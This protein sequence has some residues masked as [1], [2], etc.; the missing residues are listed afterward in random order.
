M[1]LATLD[2]TPEP[3]RADQHQAW[4]RHLEARGIAGEEQSADHVLGVA[5]HWYHSGDTGRADHW[6]RLAAESASQLDAAPEAALHWQRVLDLKIATGP[7]REEVVMRLWRA[8][9]ASGQTAES[10]ALLRDELNAQPAPTGLHRLNLELML[11]QALEALPNADTMKAGPTVHHVTRLAREVL[12][13]PGKRGPPAVLMSVLCN[14]LSR[15]DL[16]GDIVVAAERI[17]SE[18]D[19]QEEE[20][21]HT[22]QLRLLARGIASMR[23]G[24]VA[25]ALA[26]DLEATDRA[27]AADPFWTHRSA[28]LV[29]ED[30]IA[31]GRPHEAARYGEDALRGLGPVELARNLYLDM[32]AA[33][34]NA[35]VLAGEWS[36]ARDLFAIQRHHADWKKLG[37]SAGLLAEVAIWQNRLDD[38]DELCAI[39]V[40]D[41]ASSTS[42]MA[43][44][45]HAPLASACL[46][47]SRGDIPGAKAHLEPI[48]SACTGDVDDTGLWE[49]VLWGSK[50]AWLGGGTTTDRGEWEQTVRRAAE[51]THA[52]EAL[53]AAWTADVTANLDR[54]TGTDRVRSWHT[55]AEAWAI[56]GAPHHEAVARVRAAETGLRATADHDSTIEDD[57]RKAVALANRCGA[58]SIATEAHRVARRARLN[59]PGARPSPLSGP[60]A[61]L[62]ARELDVLH[63]V[64]S[65]STNQQIADQLFMSPKTASVHVSRILDKLSAR[66][67]TQAAAIAHRAGLGDEPNDVTVR[68]TRH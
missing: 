55:V 45:Y 25:A 22:R 54:A 41:M 62:T 10:R 33:L 2:L 20:D 23:H 6:A 21:D 46:A 38:A 4:A 5:H 30:L 61:R 12:A 27:R 57:L 66:N 1:R 53:G 67:R 16:P 28:A 29:V 9:S 8:L 14:V 31:L 19:V 15:V 17:L 59:L 34:V 24:D 49:A 13:D 52:V 40:A 63:L 3:Q 51:A 18:S 44:R 11:L 47:V 39:A 65:G 56:V 50:L 35:H 32:C 58:D 68:P 43:W 26:I 48:L 36:S 7:D 42:P 37:Q 64:A 60:I